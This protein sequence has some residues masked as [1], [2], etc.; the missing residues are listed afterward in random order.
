MEINAVSFTWVRCVRSRYLCRITQLNYLHNKTIIKH[1]NSNSITMKNNNLFQYASLIWQSTVVTDEL[2]TTLELDD[3]SPDSMCCCTIEQAA[4][5]STSISI[6]CKS[7]TWFYSVLSSAFIH[8]YLQM[9]RFM[10]HMYMYTT[11]ANGV[12]CLS[13]TDHCMGCVRVSA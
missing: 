3:V 9:W 11:P 4:C 13:P 12:Y 8:C 1:A 6:L 7:W 5:S 10:M 2:P